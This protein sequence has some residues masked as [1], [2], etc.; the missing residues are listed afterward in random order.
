MRY[1]GIIASFLFFL[2]LSTAP[3]DVFAATRSLSLGL[4]GADVTSLQKSLIASGYLVNR[5]AT[6]YFGS[7]TDSALKKFQCDKEII[8]SGS[9]ANGYGVYGPKTRA[10]IATALS[11]SRQSFSINGSPLTGPATGAFEI[12]GWIPYWRSATGTEDVLPHLSQLTS[13]MPFGYSVKS[14]G[15]LA[16]TARLGEEPWKSFIAEAKAKGVRVIPTVMW[17]NGVSIHKILSNTKTRIALEDEIANLVK[18]NNFDGI[19]IDFEAKHHETIN[20]F[21][22]GLRVATLLPG[23]IIPFFLRVRIA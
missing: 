17:G 13:V 22:T 23:L 5:Y 2:L 6:G 11:A 10:A 9:S 19:D 15:T 16:D 3:P 12:S 7:L 14:D 20:Y 21:S 4:S 18:K 8:C 1:A